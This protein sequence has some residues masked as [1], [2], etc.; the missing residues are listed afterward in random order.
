MVEAVCFVST[1]RT[2]TTIKKY[3]DIF[4]QHGWLLIKAEPALIDKRN[5]RYTVG[6]PEGKGKA[7]LPMGFK[8][9]KIVEI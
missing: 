5:T 6:W 1:P 2:D 7:I 8:K 9:L 4:L 3:V